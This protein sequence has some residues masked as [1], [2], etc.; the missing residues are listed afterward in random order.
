[1]NIIYFEKGGKLCTAW[2]NSSG[3][4]DKENANIHIP[5]KAKTLN[6]KYENI[7]PICQKI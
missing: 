1:M 7:N 4:Q 2:L 6:Q 5:V 3:N